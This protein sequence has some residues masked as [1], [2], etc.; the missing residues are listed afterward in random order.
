MNLHQFKPTSLK[1]TSWA[2]DQNWPPFPHPTGHVPYWKAFEYRYGD[3]LA[4]QTVSTSTE[5]CYA[6]KF[7]E[8][9]NAFHYAVGPIER[10][11][12]G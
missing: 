5:K 8:V 12:V 4:V 2:T 10:E 11:N 1:N 9:L 7:S 6:V 3:R